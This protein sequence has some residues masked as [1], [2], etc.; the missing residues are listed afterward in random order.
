[1]ADH[2]LRPATRLSL[3][4]PLPHQQA[5]RPRVHPKTA[6]PKIP[7]FKQPRMRGA[8]TFGITPPFGGLSR[9]SGQ[10]TH[11]FLTSSPLSHTN[12]T[13]RIRQYDPVRLACL[14]H[15]A[16]V[17]SEPGSNSPL[18]KF[19]SPQSEDQSDRSIYLLIYLRNVHELARVI[20]H[21]SHHF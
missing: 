7:T 20:S 8:I 17:R 2:P 15:A 18:E 16:S 6:G 5:D 11:V 21:K 4:G 12:F 13:R 3:G 14:I 9:T 1:M 10:I 19:T